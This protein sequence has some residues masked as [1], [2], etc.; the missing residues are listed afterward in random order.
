MPAALILSL[1]PILVGLALA[2]LYNA[3]RTFP[4]IRACIALATLALSGAHFLNSALHSVTQARYTLIY[5]WLWIPFAF[6]ALQLLGR[7]W[8][9][10]RVRNGF[11]ALALFFLFWQTGIAVTAEY[12]PCTWG[13]KL[14][15]LSP[16][17]PFPCHLRE[18]MAWMEPHAAPQDGV[19]VDNFNYEADDIARFAVPGR[20]VFKL[21]FASD[22]DSLLRRDIAEFVRSEHPRFVVYSAAG[23]LGRMWSLSDR[24][25]LEVNVDGNELSLH[26]L[27]ENADYRV[28]QVRY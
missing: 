21:P 16:L 18:L 15:R 14:G 26:R 10:R 22:N 1:S 24:P 17:L 11:L 2:G 6:Q 13:D 20:K 12:G 5:G 7:N 28:Y 3:V 19:V 23:Q 25:D 9:S 27:W 4:S 8:N